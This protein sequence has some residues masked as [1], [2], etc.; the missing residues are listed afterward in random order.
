[1]YK[2]LTAFIDNFF[3][4]DNIMSIFFKWQPVLTRPNLTESRPHPNSVYTFCVR[5]GSVWFCYCRPRPDLKQTQGRPRSDKSCHRKHNPV[6]DFYITT[7]KITKYLY[8]CIWNIQWTAPDQTPKADPKQTRV[9]FL[10]LLY[11]WVLS[12]QY[13][14]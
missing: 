8:I 1:M 10:G 13:C 5:P 14:K 2:F 4:P 12:T 7:E 11:C 3:L 9:S 6:L